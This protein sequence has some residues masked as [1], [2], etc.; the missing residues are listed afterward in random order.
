MVTSQATFKISVV[1]LNK[2]LCG[3]WYFK[4]HWTDYIATMW[5]IN[6][7]AKRI[8]GKEDQPHVGCILHQMVQRPSC[9]H[10]SL[11]TCCWILTERPSQNFL[12]LWYVDSFQT[13][14]RKTCENWEATVC[15]GWGRS[16]INMRVI[17]TH[18][19]SQMS[20]RGAVVWKAIGPALL[21]ATCWFEMVEGSSW[22]SSLTSDHMQPTLFASYI[23]LN[24]TKLCIA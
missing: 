16:W 23:L 10:R 24:T 7:R 13:I 15:P 17:P 2:I 9:V 19:D 20:E 18:R 3:Y 11:H 21:R 1:I 6:Y 14:L 12:F 8:R 4:M 22:A 5:Q